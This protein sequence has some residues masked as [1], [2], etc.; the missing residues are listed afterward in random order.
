MKKHIIESSLLTA[1]LLVAIP[2]IAQEKIPGKKDTINQMLALSAPGQYHQLLHAI[3]GNWHFQD[4]KLA[5]VNGSLSRSPLYEGRFFQV[6]ITGGRLQIPVADGKTKDDNYRS[7]QLEG[8]DNV[9]M[10]FVTSSVNNHIGSDIQMQIGTYD[11]ATHAF[12][13]RWESELIPSQKIRNKR[14]LTIT[15][16]NSYTEDYYEEKNGQYK[17]VRTLNY[18]RSK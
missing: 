9:R 4:A 12:T 6:V 11:S 3:T 2:A 5:F 18:T 17:K 13:Y 7:L 1:I 14:V 8:Y 10:Q 15:G 16:A